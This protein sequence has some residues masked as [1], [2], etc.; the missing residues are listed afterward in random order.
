MFILFLL[1]IISHDMFRPNWPSLS[2][3]AVVL[4]CSSFVLTSGYLYIG[5]SY[6]FEKMGPTTEGSNQR[7]QIPLNMAIT[8]D[9]AHRLSLS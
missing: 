6:L 4:F 8:L 2:V 1:F 3:Q 5:I 9:T 7:L